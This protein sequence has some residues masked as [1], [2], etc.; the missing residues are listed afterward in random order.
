MHH[1]VRKHLSPAQQ[2]RQLGE[3][4]RYAARLSRLVAERRMV[5]V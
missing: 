5:S 3:V 1:K 4:D 2:L